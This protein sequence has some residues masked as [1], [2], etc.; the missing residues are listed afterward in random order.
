MGGME[1]LE[2]AIR[3]DT[4]CDSGAGREIDLIV[5]EEFPEYP[6]FIARNDR[7]IREH[8]RA[9][10]EWEPGLARYL[11]ERLS[12]VPRIVIGGGHIGLLAFQLWQALPDAAEI[13]VFEPDS[14]NAALLS[15][16][17][18]RWG[19]SPVRVMPL[20]LSSKTGVLSLAQNPHNTGDNRL[21]ASIPP[22]LAAGGGDPERWSRQAVLGVTLDDFW[23][24]A[25]LDLLLLDTQGWEPEVMRGARN[26]LARQRPLV[27]FEW[28]PRALVA[29]EVDLEGFLRWIEDDLAMIVSVV[30]PEASGL[31]NA[32]DDL[33]DHV[34][35]VRGL[36]ELLLHRSGPV[37]HVELLATPREIR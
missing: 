32:S 21:W 19:E 8:V 36:T 13:V 14:L 2:H 18:L 3:A 16:N 27:L 5:L 7:V 15:L 1:C 12:R 31:P 29:R 10:G 17:I 25:P 24:D 6:F 33:R 26:L 28:W 20:A 9:T 23:G 35:D 4:G 22:E 34:L 37:A 30:P 11:A